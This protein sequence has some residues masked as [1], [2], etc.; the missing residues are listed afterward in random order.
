M[1]TETLAPHDVLLSAADHMESVGYHGTGTWYA[2]PDRPNTSACC[3]DGAMCIVVGFDPDGQEDEA[4][5]VLAKARV[6]LTD[7][8]IAQG[9]EPVLDGFDLHPT[10]TIAAW[11]D[12]A[13]LAEVVRVLRQVGGAK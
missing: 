12:K 11:N 4:P 7:H 5:P 9:A 3:A 2:D 1:N 6:L 10:A 8:L 13:D